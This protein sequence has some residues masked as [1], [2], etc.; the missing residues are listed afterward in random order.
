MKRLIHIP[1]TVLTILLLLAVS[2]CRTSQNTD[3][4]RNE[5][6]ADSTFQIADGTYE[7]AVALAGGTGKASVSSPAKLTVQD[8][9]MTASIVWSS[10][11]YDYMLVNDVRYDAEILDGRSVFEIPVAALDEEFPVIADT[12][13]MSTPHEIAYTLFF[14]A[15]SLTEESESSP[16]APS[17]SSPAGGSESSPA[18]ESGSHLAGE[19]ES[20]LTGSS[21]AGESEVM[22]AVPEWSNLS[23]ERELPLSYATQFRMTEYTGGYLLADINTTGRF[24]IIPE[25]LPVPEG[26]E[27]D[28]VPLCQPLDKIYLAATSAMDFFRTLDAV[29]HIRLSGTDEDG[30]YIPEAK[31]ALRDGSLLF[32]GKYN[33]PDYELIFSEQCDLA[34]ESTMIYHS[35]KIKE[36]LETLGVP[37]L[38]ERSS[39]EEHP[40]GR[41]E[42]IRFYGALL[43][44]EEEAETLFLKEAANAEALAEQTGTGKTAA[45]FYINAAGTVNVRKSEDYVSRMIDMAGGRYIF[46]GLNS[47][48]A[49]STVNMTMEAF[50]DGAKNADLLIYNSTIDGELWTMDELLAKSPLL[51]DFKAVKDGE[52]WCTGKNLFQEPMG[53]GRL[54]VDIHRVLTGDVP[55]DGVLTYLHR[56]KQ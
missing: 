56:L 12:T 41:M 39:Y 45:F 28:I 49:L 54:I 53:L 37:V 34:I 27:A 43:G 3:S 24:L 10:P 5:S 40:L 19:S 21:P 20:S 35:P 1:S 29:D 30:W 48:N 7:I 47:G 18:G 31:Q 52:V 17:E 42:W 16:A 51:A 32:A 25:G 44:R 14:D 8:G 38:V 46:S 22:S 50:Y 9:K 4:A 33:A 55:D 2:G 15:S 6:P 23:V 26:L 13:A 11:N 36:Q